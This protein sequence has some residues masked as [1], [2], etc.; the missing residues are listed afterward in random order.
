MQNTRLNVLH[1]MNGIHFRLLI[2]GFSLSLFE[3]MNLFLYNATNV[4]TPL[5]LLAVQCTS[6]GQIGQQGCGRACLLNQT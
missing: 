4:V 3:Q 2:D 1:P 5:V 6:S